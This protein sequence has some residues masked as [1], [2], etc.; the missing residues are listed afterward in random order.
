MRLIF[1]MGRRRRRRQRPSARSGRETINFE[2]RRG[3][4]AMDVS[5]AARRASRPS[6]SIPINRPHCAKGC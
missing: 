1:V 3:C 2:Y 6:S 4:P 5:V